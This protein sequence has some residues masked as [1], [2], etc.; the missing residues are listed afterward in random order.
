MYFFRKQKPRP[1]LDVLQQEVIK[2]KEIEQQLRRQ[3]VDHAQLLNNLQQELT[4]RKKAEEALRREKAFV[5]LVQIIEIAANRATSSE[6]ALDFALHRLCAHTGSPI[7]HVYKKDASG[8]LVSTPIWYLKNGSRFEPLRRVTAVTRF[9]RGVGLPG[10]VLATGRPTWISDVS[11]DPYFVRTK[12]AQESNLCTA[13]AFAV[14]VGR[15]VVA[16]LEFF[17]TE[18]AEPDGSLLEVMAHI[19][20]QLGRIVERKRAESILRESEERFRKIFEEG[21]LGMAIIGLDYRFLKVNATLSQLVGYSEA[22]LSTRTFADITHPDDVEESLSLAQQLFADEISAYQIEKRYLDHRGEVIWI[23]LTASIIRGKEGPALYGLVMIQDITERKQ[24]EMALRQARD[25][26]ELRVQ[27]RTEELKLAN[28]E[29]R[30]F[31]YIVSHDLRSPLVN[32]KGFAGELRIALSEITSLLEPLLPHLDTQQQQVLKMALQEDVPEALEFIDSSVSRMSHLINALLKLSRLGHR[33]FLFEQLDMQTLVQSTLDSL[34]HQIEQNQV[35]V[36]VGNLPYLV[37]DRVS[38][39]QIMGNLLTNAVLYLDPK[40]PG[41]IEITAQR[42]T[43]QTTFHIKDNGRGIAKADMHKIFE[44]FRRIGKPTTPG[45]G[46]GLAYVQT[47]VRRHGGRIWCQSELG[48]GT[49]FRFTI[50]HRLTPS[51]ESGL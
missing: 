3:V 49:T 42:G 48:V 47:L 32:L 2:G 39:Q 18:L 12:A 6:E 35:S 23:D 1:Q 21:P 19:G 22:Q 20:T 25:E 10:R 33:E 34:A 29:V 41:Q 15:E 17:S 50:S 37:A 44:P 36:S 28:E 51:Q 31:A 45:E 7:G 43:N 40:R 38:L 13:F 16:V 24:A 14:L 9:G 8:D 26:L 27:K 5:D 46:M 11:Q 30:R 4:K